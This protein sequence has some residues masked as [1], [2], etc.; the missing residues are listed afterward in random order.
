MRTLQR[1]L[2]RVAAAVGALMVLSGSASALIITSNAGDT[3]NFGGGAGLGTGACTSVAV[4]PVG[5]WQSNNPSGNGAV[6][7]SF[8]NSF[9]PSND[10]TPLPLMII[11]ETFSGA[12]TLA[13]KVWADDTARVVLDGTQIFAPI[14][15][16]ATVT[17]AC[18]DGPIGC[19]SFENA[20]INM[21]LGPGSHSL[22][23][24]VFQYFGDGF[25]TLYSGTLT[26][27]PLPAAL[28][29]FL[30]ALAGLGL[31]GWRRRRQE[32]VG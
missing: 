21:A 23:I 18:V 27:V 1:R 19:Q 29:L 20:A 2:V 22:D 30:S 32:T 7:I 11:T 9:F 13:L 15:P 5:A 6:W 16:L 4:T 14:S 28:P 31:M 25:G 17:G 3:C 26:A 24:E 10:T 8:T 12:G